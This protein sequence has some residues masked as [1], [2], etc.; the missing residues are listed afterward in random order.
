MP[1][2]RG[3]GRVPRSRGK[4]HPTVTWTPF[5]KIYSA[6]LPAGSRL[7]RDLMSRTWLSS[8]CETRG[9]VARRT[10]ASE[11]HVV[12][13][14][15][16]QP[17]PPKISRAKPTMF[18]T[19]SARLDLNISAWRPARSLLVIRSKFDACAPNVSPEYIGPIAMSRSIT[20]QR[21]V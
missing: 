18:A 3:H 10:I 15:E 21:K 20:S 7:L 1:T 11:E 5:W 2:L 4:F 9:G 13:M 14:L 8:C 19:R 17:T 16:Y 6:V 12:Q